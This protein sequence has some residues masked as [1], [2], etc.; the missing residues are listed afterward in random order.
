MQDEYELKAIAEKT[1]ASAKTAGEKY[2]VNYVTTDYRQLLCDPDIDLVV[3]GTRHNLHAGQVADTIKAGKNVLVEKPLAMN[4]DELSMIEKA[5]KENPDVVAAVGFNRRYSPLIQKAKHI[6]EKNAT[7][8]VINYRVNAGY[9]PPDIWIQDLEEGGG[10]IVGEVCHFIDLIA[11]LASGRVKEINAIH[12]PPDGIT[13]KS[14]DNVII[15]MAFDNG[16]IGVLTYASIGGKEMEKERIEI[17]TNGSSLV[18]NDF[19]ELQTFNCDEKGIRLKEV[20]KGHKAL[21]RELSFRLRGSE[22]LI[23]PFETDIEMTNLTL[24]VLD[25]IH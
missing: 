22:S 2:N 16:S 11:Y 13:I 3:I 23:L 14:E 6:I 21:I 20:D 17:L 8:V 1:P 10:R 15:S 9:F 18:I 19:I 5:I 7:P 4:H 12:I 24:S 25:Q